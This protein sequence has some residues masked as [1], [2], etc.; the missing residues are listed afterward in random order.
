[1]PALIMWRV[2][3]RRAEEVWVDVQAPTAEKAEA[4]AVNLPRV[5]SVFGK[6][7]IRGDQAA[8]PEAAAGVREDD[9]E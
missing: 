5:I 4:D 2:R 9:N 1:M 7:A 3:V 6:S 8:R